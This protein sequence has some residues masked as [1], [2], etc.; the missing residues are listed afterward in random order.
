MAGYLL[1]IM[2]NIPNDICD[3]YEFNKAYEVIELKNNL[4]N[5]K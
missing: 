4:S 2:I 5:F 3:F 1:D